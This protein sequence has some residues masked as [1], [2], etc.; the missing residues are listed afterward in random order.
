MQTMRYMRLAIAGLMVIVTGCAGSGTTTQPTQTVQTKASTPTH[1][2]RVQRAAF[3]VSNNPTS[4][5]G[6]GEPDLED[7]FRPSA[8]VFIGGQEGR[9]IEK[10]GN[11]LVQWVIGSSVNNSPTIRIEA[12]ADL[13]GN[14]D[15]FACTL[16]TYNALDGSKIAYAIKADDG[17]FQTGREYSLLKP[18][19][20]FTIRNRLT[21]DVVHE[22]SELAAGT[23]L[24][25]A[26][27][28][29]S[30]TGQ[31]G[32]AITSFTVGHGM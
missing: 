5:A 16:D 1:Q 21:G 7:P 4:N 2:K 26:K 27:V 18:G 22:I 25:A 10:D 8:W 13:L 11:Q 29:N 23:Y 12:M 9:F 24:I 19:K 14:P 31:R 6:R 30:K 28:E 15:N 17:T 20:N 3:T 32:L